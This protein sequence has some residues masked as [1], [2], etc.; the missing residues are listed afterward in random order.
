MKEKIII[1]LASITLMI[2]VAGALSTIL[3]EKETVHAQT[4]ENQ[5][6]ST[7]RY[8]AEK[9]INPIINGKKNWEV[10]Q[11]E[12]VNVLKGVSATD[13]QGN[14]LKVF[15]SRFST[16][17]VGTKTITLTAE[18]SLNN[19]TMTTI[20]VKVTPAIKKEKKI[21]KKK[22][23]TE[24]KQVE[25]PIQQD[26]IA[27]NKKETMATEELI[28]I[29]EPV[30][31]EPEAVETTI[32]DT[33]ASNTMYVGGL[34][35]PYQN[36]GEGSGQAVIDS[37]PN[38][39]A[40]WGG[41]P[42]QSGNDGQNTH[43]IG[44]NPGIFSVLFSLGTGGQIVV[45]DGNAVPTYYSINSIFQV[46]DYGTNTASGQNVMDDLIGYGGGERITLQTCIN[47]DINLIVMASVF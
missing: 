46:D 26:F 6:L 16:K 36:A 38:V 7:P 34:A 41:S 11:G 27:V 33:W 39:I 19:K 20:E 30:V 28:E 3:E 47:D 17:E 14:A 37:D 25:Q 10:T 2:G 23:T 13:Y 15:A 5:L 21:V 22:N 31:S 29:Q 4:L 32:E 24:K 35:I 12:K 9:S 40:T 42:V 1:G 45:T 43:F 18:D 44:H 8:T